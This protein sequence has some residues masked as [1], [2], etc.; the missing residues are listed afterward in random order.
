M[1][2][3]KLLI[4]GI[5]SPQSGARTVNIT[6]A[7]HVLTHLR[8]SDHIFKGV[9]IPYEE[10]PNTAIASQMD[11]PELDTQGGY[12]PMIAY[13]HSNTVNMLFTTELAEMLKDKGIY[14][15]TSAPE[16][17]ETELQRDMPIG[18]RNPHMFYKTPNQGA[19]TFLFV[20]FDP[21]P[22]DRSGA[23]TVRLLPLP[24]MQ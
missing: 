8:F 11:M 12:H 2:I 1:I 6:S 4:S 15:F 7:A 20:A 19:A 21:N 9:P 17:V 18:F 16:V 23:M 10:Q 13:C 5:Q 24:N 14:P 22:K 3:N